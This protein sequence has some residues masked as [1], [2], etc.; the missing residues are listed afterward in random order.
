MSLLDGSHVDQRMEPVPFQLHPAS[1]L[2]LDS[3]LAKTYAEPWPGQDVGQTGVRT[4]ASAGLGVAT[5]DISLART[6][7][8]LAGTDSSLAGTDSSLAR[9]ESSLAGTDS[10]LSRTESSLARTD[11]V[12]AK[13]NTNPASV[14]WAASNEEVEAA[15]DWSWSDKD[16]PIPPKSGLLITKKNRLAEVFTSAEED[17]NVW[18]H[19]SIGSVLVGP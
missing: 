1:Q 4:V 17:D 15:P 11:S 10:S 3:H 7:L 5:D 13:T 8:S 2:P 16:T 12:L 18:V 6:D 19:A 9:I 14:L